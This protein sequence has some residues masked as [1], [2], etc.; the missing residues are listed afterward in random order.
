MLE[1]RGAGVQY[2]GENVQVLHYDKGPVEK[3]EQWLKFYD[4]KVRTCTEN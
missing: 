4:E 2:L 3:L 1:N